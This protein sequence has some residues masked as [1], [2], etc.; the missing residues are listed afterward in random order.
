MKQDK[1]WHVE[2]HRE[3]WNDI[4]D[5][6][7]NAKRVLEITV[8]KIDWCISRNTYPTQACF[9]CAYCGNRD[10]EDG[11]LFN[12][13]TGGEFTSCTDGYYRDCKQAETW[14]EQAALARKIANLPVREEV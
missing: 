13:T 12:W 2:K 10:C 9:A 5:E 14:Q 11:C 7:E 8:T 6:I 3:M 4:A 1:V